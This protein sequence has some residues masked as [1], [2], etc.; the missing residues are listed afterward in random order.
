M[1][2][3]KNTIQLI[4]IVILVIILAFNCCAKLP[5]AN[6]PPMLSSVSNFIKKLPNELSGLSKGEITDFEKDCP[7][8]GYGV[9][10]SS[11]C[12][13]DCLLLSMYIYDQQIPYIPNEITNEIVVNEFK[14]VASRLIEIHSKDE[15][16]VLDYTDGKLIEP[17]N[18]KIWF[19][20]M[21]L[22]TDGI[23]RYSVLGITAFKGKFFKFRIT[24][25]ISESGAHKS[26]V[27]KIIQDIVN[28]ILTTQ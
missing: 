19:M 28:N 9:S 14:N 1:K 5:R 23:K 10:Y 22:F 24:T 6:K 12:F 11:D 3:I 17:V 7:G 8:C 27:N 20:E 21:E 13:D 15:S 18:Q 2:M 4:H 25:P 16:E 26:R